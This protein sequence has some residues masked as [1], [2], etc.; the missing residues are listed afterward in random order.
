[1]EIK[2]K[3]VEESMNINLMK[4]SIKLNME[5]NSFSNINENKF[6]LPAYFEQ[7][8]HNM[9]FNP[10]NRDKNTDKDENNINLNIGF[11]NIKEN[12]IQKGKFFIY[13]N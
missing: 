6:Y 13:R 11:N 5:K 3:L 4:P 7:I 2:I 12:P 1:M 8:S 9:T 10:D